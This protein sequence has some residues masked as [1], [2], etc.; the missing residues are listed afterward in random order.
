LES[1]AVENPKVETLNW[2]AGAYGSSDLRFPLLD[3]PLL[4]FP[5][6]KS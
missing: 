6:S 2:T 4:D 1:P 3:F 5:I